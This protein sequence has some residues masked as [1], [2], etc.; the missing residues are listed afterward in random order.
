MIGRLDGRRRAFW[1][2]QQPC[3]RAVGRSVGKSSSSDVTGGARPTAAHPDPRGDSSKKNRFSATSGVSLEPLR[4]VH[5]RATELELRCLQRDR[6]TRACVAVGEQSRRAD[7]FS[8]PTATVSSPQVGVT[9][10]DD[11]EHES[12]GEALRHV[13]FLPGDVSENRVSFVSG[14][15]EAD[16]RAEPGPR[17]KRISLKTKASGD[18]DRLV[19]GIGS[20]RTTSRE[21]ERSVRCWIVPA[22][23]RQPRAGAFQSRLTVM[24][25]TCSTSATSSSLQ[26]TEEPQLDD[27]GGARV[28]RRNARQLGVEIEQ[29]FTRAAASHPSTAGERDPSLVTAALVRDPGAR[30]VDENAPHGLGRDREEVGA[31]LVR[32]RLVPDQTERARSPPRSV[33]AYG[34][35]VPVGAGARRAGGVA[36]ARRRTAGRGPVHR[37]L[38]TGPAS[39]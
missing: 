7:L 10:D 39:R 9:G 3:G 5:G 27:A 2:A 26:A 37:P 14:R 32:E 11:A 20:T 35:A 29:L 34:W 23:G 4:H 24:I 28:A 22:G 17:R 25:D 1:S 15:A 19:P 12:E 6:L 18:G 21:S 8:P 38:A 33:Q 31:I 16:A 30:V 13:S 36:A